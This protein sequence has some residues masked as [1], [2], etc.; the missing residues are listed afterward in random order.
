MRILSVRVGL[1]WEDVVIPV[2]RLARLNHQIYF[3]K[4]ATNHP[5]L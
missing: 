5:K 4:H 1:Q 3:E 2:G